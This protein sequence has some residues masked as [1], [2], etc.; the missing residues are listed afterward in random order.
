MAVSCTLQPQK[1]PD[2]PYQPFLEK[3]W[4]EEE[5]ASVVKVI[6]SRVTGGHGRVAWFN[7]DQRS[8]SLTTVSR[9][10]ERPNLIFWPMFPAK[11]IGRYNYFILLHR[12]EVPGYLDIF[13]AGRDDEAEVRGI[14][15]A[16]ETMRHKVRWWEV[17]N[18]GKVCGEEWREGL[19]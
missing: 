18:G 2:Q 19:W 9:Q 15:V 17:R 6:R 7:Q 8:T 14:F 1:A 5:L 10:D 4:R 3:N 11:T 12:R 13:V 16:G